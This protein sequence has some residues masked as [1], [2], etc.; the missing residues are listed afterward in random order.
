MLGSAVYRIH[1]YLPDAV[2]PYFEAGVDTLLDLLIKANVIY[3]VKRTRRAAEEG[4]PE[5][6]WRCDAPRRSIPRLC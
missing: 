1:E 5:S 6:A 4:E 2:V 3:D